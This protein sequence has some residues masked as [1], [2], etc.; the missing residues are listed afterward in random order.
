MGA[1][2]REEGGKGRDVPKMDSS[3]RRCPPGGRKDSGGPHCAERRGRRWPM[4]QVQRCF[5]Q[6]LTSSLWDLCPY[7]GHCNMQTRRLMAS[8]CTG[9]A[10]R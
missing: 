4:T 5:Y 1:I 2:R 9:M 10:Y 3:E 6:L 7:R 8:G